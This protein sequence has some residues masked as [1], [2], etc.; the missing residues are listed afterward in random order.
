MAITI[1]STPEA[2]PSMHDDLWY[3][4]TSTNV[5]Q[6]NFKYVFDVYVNS[7]L[8]A[9]IKTFADPASN[10]GIFNA[11]N[12][13]RNYWTSYFKPNT[14]TT[15]W[16]YSGHDIYVPFEIRFGEE[17]DGSLYTNLASGNYKAFNFYNPIFRDPSTSYFQPYISKWLTNRDKSKLE[18]SFGEHLYIGWM[19]AAA[20]TTSLTMTVQKYLPGGT[21]EGS[22]VTSSSESTQSFVLVDLSPAAINA[23]LG[24]NLITTSTYQYGVKINYG[25]TSSDELKILVACNPKFTPVTLHFLNQLGG[26]DSFMFRAVNRQ[27]R[28]IERKQYERSNW[29]LNSSTMQSYDSYKRMY[30]GANVF[31]VQQGVSFRLQSDFIN[32]TD[33]TWLNELIGSPEVYLENGGYYYP[34]AVK[35]A[36]WDEK[37][38]AAD[39]IFNMNLEVDYG[40]KINSQYR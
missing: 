36:T 3:V 5:A 12:I 10:K 6:V 26:Y 15:F 11:A 7:S 24:Q 9:R 33:F 18:C 25:G 27:S 14:T 32:Q 37:I 30:E 20:S 31:S 39:K 8:V 22:P 19:N 4:V 21:A 40:K 28:T 23:E 1:N 29:Q 35:T 16:S 34:V 17:Y 2:Y 13:I 38:R